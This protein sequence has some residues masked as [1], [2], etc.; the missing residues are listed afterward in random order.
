MNKALADLIK[1]SNI[2]GKDPS[3]V[4][5]GGGNTSVK[6][7]DNKYMY[8]KASGTALKDMSARKG[9][10]RLKLSSV[11]DIIKD[12]SLTS[13]NTFDRETEITHRLLLT[14]DDSLTDG[15]RP[16]VESHL[17]AFLDRC[18]IHLH[19]DV[20]G[21]FVNAKQGRTKLLALFT[22]QKLPPLWVPYID[23]GFSLAKKIA[24]LIADYKAQ[25]HKAP[26]IIF[27]QKHGLIVSADTPTAALNLVRKVIKRCAAALKKQKISKAKPPAK[28]LIHDAKLAIRAAFFNTTGSYA[29]VAFF[30]DALVAHYCRSK[31]TAKLLAPAS[32]APDELVYSNGPALWLDSADPQKITTKI[33]ARIKKAA[34]PPLTFLVKNLGL[35]ITAPL[36]AAP[37]IKD[38]VKSSL[39]IRTQASRLGGIATLNAR[40]R[41]FI[42][43]WEAESYRKALA[44]SST[45]GPLQNRIA[46]VTGAGS[47]LGKSIAIG[48]ARAG[49]S[50]ALA[51]IDTAAIE[52]TAQAV[53]TELPQIP[54]LTI[55]CDVTKESSVENAYKS[56]IDK[57]GGLDILVNAA[58][59]APPYALT[60]MPVEKWRLALEVNL[61][62]YLLMAK[63]AAR[64][65]I[66]QSIGG[67]IIKLSSKS[68]LEP[69]KNNTPYNATKAGEIHMAR[70]WALEL[71]PHNIR[72]NSVCAGNVFEGSKIWNP[73]YIKTC[74]KKYGIKPEQVIPYY[75]SKTALNK[76]IKG[77]DVADTV[78]FLCSDSARRITGQTIITDAGQVFTR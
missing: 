52:K 38:G 29:P 14:C 19:P 39:F 15:A 48:L 68:G 78:T 61:T 57:F 43:R 9:Y 33:N 41:Q 44:A 26:A 6:S 12:R 10:R 31:S 71:G 35:F 51:D 73:Q 62:G 72:V 7:A 70:G 25:Y 60:E 27:L 24:K 65:M 8:I 37:S 75:V 22:D 1:I 36:T 50:V 5:G 47:G 16:S 28:D 13:L 2:T 55:T 59:I 32:L 63:H 20:I 67:S 3:L 49:A 56:L 77:Q 42:D 46:V 34:K 74:A 4:Q 58:G 64:I 18:V 66:A 40:Q 76:E 11:L 54:T 45:P 23:P 21:A 53:K 30:S 69:S 17:H